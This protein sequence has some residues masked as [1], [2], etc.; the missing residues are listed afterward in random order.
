MLA[1]IGFSICQH[2]NGKP[3]LESMQKFFNAGRIY[4]K[5]GSLNVWVFE[6]N[7]RKD[8]NEKI[9]PFFKKYVMTFSCKF[10]DGTYDN[11]TRILKA[12]LNKEHHTL[13]GLTYIVKCIFKTNP[14]GKG[15]KRKRTL[16]EILEI[17][18]NSRGALQENA[19]I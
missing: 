17:I 11:F 9:M 4:L 15:K 12:L 5:H 2:I 18:K 6:V 7:D 1:N 13:Y 19:C 8:L 14:S 16:N 3:L 10:R